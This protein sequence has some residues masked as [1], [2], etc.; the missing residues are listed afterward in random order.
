MNLGGIKV[1]SLQ[2]EE[3]VA[4]FRGVLEAAAIAVFDVRQPNVEPSSRRRIEAQRKRD[5][6][7][8]HGDGPGTAQAGDVGVG[9]VVEMVG[10]DGS[11]VG[12]QGLDRFGRALVDLLFD[13]P[14]LY[15]HLPVAQ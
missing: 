1:S 12:R 7:E 15:I 9:E 10:G 14:F 2:I 3:I 4:S 11:D 8:Q 13:R 5:G 6:R